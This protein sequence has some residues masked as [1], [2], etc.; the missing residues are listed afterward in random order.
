VIDG[1]TGYMV[2]PGDSDP[3]AEAI[4]KLWADQAA[5]KHLGEN[6]RELM[7]ERFDKEIQFD[8]FLDYFRTLN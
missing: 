3:L 4:Y 7:A 2:A 1:E 6:A 5:F 8:R